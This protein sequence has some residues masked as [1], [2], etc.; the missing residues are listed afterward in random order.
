ML[1]FLVQYYQIVSYPLHFYTVPHIYIYPLSLSQVIT[2]LS[3]FV[4]P[5][6]YSYCRNESLISVSP[7]HLFFP[8]HSL[9]FYYYRYFLST[10]PSFLLPIANLY[11]FFN[12]FIFHIFLPSPSSSLLQSLVFI[13]LSSILSLFLSSF[14]IPLC[15]CFPDLTFPPL[16]TRFPFFRQIHSLSLSQLF[17]FSWPFLP[18]SV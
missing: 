18:L 11:F 1:I 9:S 15:L 13:Y 12:I 14:C 17:Y 2:V 8:L 7:L 16:H 6:I 4:G 5:L 10:L 3:L